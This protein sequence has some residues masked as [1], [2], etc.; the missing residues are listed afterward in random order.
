MNFMQYGFSLFP[1][2]IGK[3]NNKMPKEYYV[4]FD[5]QPLDSLHIKSDGGIEISSVLGACIMGA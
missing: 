1:P 3:L 5:S 2:K 4:S